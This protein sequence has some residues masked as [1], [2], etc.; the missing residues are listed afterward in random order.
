MAIGISTLIDRLR[1]TL[2]FVPT[3]MTSVAAILAIG[4]VQ[5]EQRYESPLSDV[6]GFVYTGGPDGAR[7]ILSTVAGSMITIAG[8]SFSIV[9]VAL[10]LASNQF[11]HRLLRNFMRDRG[12]Q[13]VLGTFIATF[14]YCLLTLR[15][16]RSVEGEEFVPHLSVTLGIGF[17]LLSLAILIYFIHHVSGSIQADHVVRVVAE[18][19]ESCVDRLFPE[20]LGP[21]ATNEDRPEDLEKSAWQLRPRHDGY[22][23]VVNEERLMSLAEE[24]ALRLVLLVRPG[25]FLTEG[26]S[27][28]RVSPETS[29]SDDLEDSLVSCFSLGGS[30]TTQQDVDFAIEQL[31][32]VA[33]RALSPGINAPFTAAACLDRLLQAFSRLIDREFPS[34]YRTS[35]DG[36]LRVVAPTTTFRALCDQAFD[37]IRHYGGDAPI[38]LYRMMDVLGLLVDRCPRAD[39]RTVLLEHAAETRRAGEQHIESEKV[40]QRLSEKYGRIVGQEC[41]SSA[42]NDP[43]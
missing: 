25:S 35:E 26:I 31:V 43:H 6:L 36:V 39:R 3:V 5:F 23:Q 2:W 40:L 8:V 41:D 13:I 17:G 34:A 7:A 10:S 4:M 32:E 19:L 28:A 42:R 16:I 38:V 33:V 9:I 21:A 15:T 27:F 1:S 30:R 29:W 24:H 14:V 11:G 20:H 12:N 37:P 18:E 22:L